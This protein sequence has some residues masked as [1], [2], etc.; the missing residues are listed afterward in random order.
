MHPAYQQPH[1]PIPLLPIYALWI[2]FADRI[3][4]YTSTTWHN[5]LMIKPFAPATN[6]RS[7]H[8]WPACC[9]STALPSSHSSG[10]H[11]GSSVLPA[12]GG[13]CLAD[14]TKVDSNSQDCFPV[15]TLYVVA[16]CEKG[17]H[18]VSVLLQAP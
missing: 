2:C 8:M 9:I 15:C 3:Q 17:Q 11:M 13:I 4:V 7:F 12:T 10:A 1:S 18:Y 6:R 14:L 16:L 5:C